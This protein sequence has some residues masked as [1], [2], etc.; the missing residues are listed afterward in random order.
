MSLF[1]FNNNLMH[2]MIVHDMAESRK[3]TLEEAKK[4]IASLSFAEYH[5]LAEASADIVPPSGKPLS[6]N[7]GSQPAATA[8]A[9]KTPPTPGKPP[10]PGQEE[11]GVEVRN[12]KTGKMEVMV[13]ADQQ[14]KEAEDLARM[15]KLA[16]IKE[17][18]SCGAT[19]AGSI[20]VAP[21]AM[22]KVNKRQPTDEQLKKEYT[23]KEAAKTIV[24]DTKPGQ[25]SGELSATLAANGRKT[26]SRN[27]NGFKK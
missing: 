14:M 26:A 20:A 9:T 4:I 1:E 24:G 12:P 11:E 21:A 6:P 25:A 27:N 15:R 23:P 8:P 18:A 16:G 13:P 17:N 2:N 10:V 3:V 22:G 19:G 7:A 5:K